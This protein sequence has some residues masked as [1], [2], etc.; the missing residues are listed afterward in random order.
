MNEEKNKELIQKLMEKNKNLEE[1]INLKS[2]TRGRIWFT[3]TCLRPATKLEL[4][5]TAQAI[6]QNRRLINQMVI[7]VNSL[8]I[9]MSEIV[10][11]LKSRGD[12]NL[13][14]DINNNLAKKLKK[15][16]IDDIMYR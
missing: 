5:R 10:G 13:S 11:Y 3:L 9:K 16:N 6:V 2:T 4:A 14:K 12:S 1:R 8:T 7:Q 15:K